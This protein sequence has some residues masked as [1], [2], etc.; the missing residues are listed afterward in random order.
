MTRSNLVSCVDNQAFWIDMVTVS[1][2]KRRSID[3]RIVSV[4]RLRR[5]RRMLYVCTETRA[6]VALQCG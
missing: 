6:V 4:R 2:P 1:S 3:A 5:F